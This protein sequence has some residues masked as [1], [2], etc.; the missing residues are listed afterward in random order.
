MSPGEAAFQMTKQFGFNKFFG[1]R[2][3]V[4]FNKG[5]V[6]A[7]RQFVEQSGCQFFSRPAFPKDQDAAGRGRGHFNFFS[8]RLHAFPYHFYSGQLGF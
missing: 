8:Q 6:T 5:T 7:I 3:A 4:H 1:D 2:G